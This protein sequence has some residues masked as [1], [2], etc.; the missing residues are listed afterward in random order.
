M[1]TKKQP[2]VVNPASPFEGDALSREKVCTD[3]ADFI[4]QA[5]TP[6]VLAVDAPW[7]AGKT[8]FLQ[9][10]EAVCKQREIPT[11]FFNAWEAD[12]HSDALAAMIGEVGEQIQ[13]QPK[14]ELSEAVKQAGQKVLSRRGLWGMLKGALKSA[15]S[16][17]GLAPIQEAM[18]ESLRKF[19][20]AAEYREYRGALKEFKESLEA[21][22]DV[23]RSGKPLVFFVDELD[24]CRP[25][26][27]VE[28]LEK[29]KHIFDAEGVFFVVAVNKGE[30]AKTIQSVYGGIDANVYLRKFFDREHW[31]VSRSGFI[32]S[33]LDNLGFAEH[34]QRRYQL[35]RYLY[36][37]D[38]GDE[39]ERIVALCDAYK[40]S[41]RDCEQVAQV[42][43]SAMMS[44]DHKPVVHPDITGFFAA[45]SVAD[46]Q[47]FREY[48]A[49]VAG[50]NETGHGLSQFP[51]AKLAEDYKKVTGRDFEKPENQ[52]TE[53]DCHLDRLEWVYLWCCVNRH[54]AD[55]EYRDHVDGIAEDSTHSGHEF[56]SRVQRFAQDQKRQELNR[57]RFYGGLR[58]H[59]KTVIDS[60][61]R[62]GGPRFNDG[63]AE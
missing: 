29:I 21:Y 36:P 3:L 48:Q 37:H 15:G 61:A 30:L 53:E 19:D 59:P 31:L 51:F 8:V 12:F 1:K 60:V 46:Q 57:N 23:A 45:M 34:L 50:M 6:Y 28:V 38:P 39:I 55:T 27:A 33:V 22:V 62:I 5:E 14:G 35:G 54:T 44:A 16:A 7:G 41:L 32:A 13:P 24:R 18:L 20:P 63:K 26:F 42:F 10:L 11:V 47:R 49:V 40:L 25:V 56:M 2:L 58:P 9:M 17:A 52:K 43:A 4:V